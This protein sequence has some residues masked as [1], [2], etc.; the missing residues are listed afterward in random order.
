MAILK[1]TLTLLYILTAFTSGLPAQTQVYLGEKKPL[2]LEPMVLTSNIG[3]QCLV[4]DVKVPTRAGHTTIVL[5]LS[6]EVAV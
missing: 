2:L 6:A 3:Q 1:N 4:T 5:N